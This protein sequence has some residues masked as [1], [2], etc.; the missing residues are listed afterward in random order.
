MDIC[1]AHSEERNRNRYPKN[2]LHNALLNTI[3]LPRTALSTPPD[4]ADRRGVLIRLQD[5]L[6]VSKKR[7]PIE[8]C[9]RDS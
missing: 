7:R 5:T 4:E 1:D 9:G 8:K 6:F 3:P 2:V